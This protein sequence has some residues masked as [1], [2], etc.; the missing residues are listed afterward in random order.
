MGL[1]TAQTG[2]LIPG[3]PETGETLKK[4]GEGYHEML[5]WILKGGYFKYLN[6]LL[7]F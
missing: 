2:I 6:F 4:E 5:N 7:E 1:Y 3:V